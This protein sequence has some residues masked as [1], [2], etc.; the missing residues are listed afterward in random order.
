ME[1][2]GKERQGKITTMALNNPEFLVSEESLD[3][4]DRAADLKE[5][6]KQMEKVIREQLKSKLDKKIGLIKAKSQRKK[7][8]K[9]NQPI[10]METIFEGSIENEDFDAFQN[11]NF[12]LDSDENP[13][14]KKQ[15]TK[16]QEEPLS[17]EAKKIKGEILKKVLREN[18]IERKKALNLKWKNEELKKKK[19][20]LEAKMK[21]DKWA[22]HKQELED[23]EKRKKVEEAMRQQEM[24]DEYVRQMK[25]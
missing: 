17:E 20:E 25:L 9:K 10:G 13:N 4:E 1:A 21:A 23:Q 19:I 22:K 12:L 7:L 15:K 11:D 8:P 16:K 18:M 5:E 6:A 14:L 24:H 3:T 2:K